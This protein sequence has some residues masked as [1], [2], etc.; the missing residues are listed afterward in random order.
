LAKSGATSFPSDFKEVLKRTE[1]AETRWVVVFSPTGCSGMLSGLG[2]LGPDSGKVEEI[3]PDRKT[4]IATIGPTTRGYLRETFDFEPDVCAE[5]PS[6]EGI[7][8]GIRRFSER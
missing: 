1:Y 6:P 5:T 4:F 2:M 3:P 8:D 7:W